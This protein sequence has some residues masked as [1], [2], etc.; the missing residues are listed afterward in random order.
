MPHDV[1]LIATLAIGFALAFVFGFAAN[2]LGL[3]PLVGYLVAGVLVGPFTPGFVGDRASTGQLAEIGVMLLM[4]GVGLHFS[5]DDLIAVRGIAI[6]GAVGQI[7]IA[8]AIGA[9]MAAAWGWDLGAGIVL[10]LSLSVAS[11]VVLLKA[12]EERNAVETPNGR[13]AIGWLVVED[14]AM[15]LALVLLPAFAEALGGNPVDNGH[16]P[17]D[18]GILLALGITLAKVGAFV[19]ILLLVGP[20]VLPWLLRQV[21]RTGSRELFTLC[22]LAVALGIAFGSAKLFGVS[23]ALGAFFAGMVLHESDLSH[24]AATNSLPLQDAFAVLFFLSVGMLFD[25]S[26]IWR[27][28]SMVAAVM[29]LILVGKSLVALG[30]VVLLGYPLSTALTVSASLAQIGEFSFIL[31]GL[32]ISYGLMAPEGLNLILAGALLSITLNPLVFAG[33]DRMIRW[34]RAKPKLNARFEESCGGRFARLKEELE[35]TRRRQAEKAASSKTFTPEELV[36]RFPLFSGL[37]PEQREVLVLHFGSRAAEPGERIIRAGEKADAVYFVCQGEV[38]VSVADRRIKLG[39]GDF[40]G[41][42]ALISGLP[43]SADVTALDYCKF[44]TL[45]RRDFRQFLS[46][47]PDIRDQ[48]AAITA[49]RREMNRQLLS[50]GA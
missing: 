17:A 21:A 11:T 30:I 39:P 45:S 27:E 44:A 42:M 29:V 46:R 9:G 41:E 12:L 48:I 32:G 7:L 3:P 50:K 28:P 6:P 19:A 35:S 14:L 38:E 18:K 16:A 1:A 31:S 20:R 25:P 47:Y 23:Y 34:V 15:V 22:V 5:V 8:T 40:F 13:I 43:R 33:A 2:R 49:Q 26:I 24:K 36:D 4:F 37:T 10:G